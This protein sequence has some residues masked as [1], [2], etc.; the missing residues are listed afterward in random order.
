MIFVGTGYDMTAHV[1]KSPGRNLHNPLSVSMNIVW[2]TLK[3][4]MRKSSL[5]SFM[6][7]K[8]P[9]KQGEDHVRRNPEFV[10]E[11]LDRHMSRQAHTADPLFEIGGTIRNRKIGKLRTN[12]ELLFSRRLPAR[13]NP[14]AVLRSSIY[15]LFFITKLI[16]SVYIIF[17]V[18]PY[19]Q[20]IVA[21]F[22]HKYNL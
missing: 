21:R 7:A 20:A 18:F 1:E 16:I 19:C 8:L 9:R 10:V 2:D 11:D 5:T 13:I 17:I 3:K 15:F 22:H 12:A 4:V 6:N 14:V